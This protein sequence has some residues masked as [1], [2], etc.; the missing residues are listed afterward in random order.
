VK[1]L[2]LCPFV[3]LAV[4]SAIAQS[5]F[6]DDFVLVKGGTFTMGSPA[7]EPERGTDEATTEQRRKLTPQVRQAAHCG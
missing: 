6:P 2:F 3:L 5:R 1:M 4:V 7:N